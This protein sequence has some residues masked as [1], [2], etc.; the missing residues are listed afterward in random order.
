M[1]TITISIS[2][3]RLQKL[4]EKASRFHIAPEDLVRAS[5]EDLLAR[6]EEGFQRAVGYVLDK[7]AELYRRLA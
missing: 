3:D 4:Q 7:N 5:L 6:P 2:E 1:S